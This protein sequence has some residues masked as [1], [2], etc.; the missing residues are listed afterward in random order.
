MTKKELIAIPPI[1]SVTIE[2]SMDIMIARD[3]ARRAASL[4]GFSPA[5]RAQLAGAAAALAELVLKTGSAHELNYN[6]VRNGGA[7]TGVQIS[8]TAPWLGSVAA[9]NVVIA[10][11][12]KMGD[13]VDD[14]EVKEGDAPTIVMT[15]WLSDPRKMQMPSD[16][17]GVEV[18]ASAIEDDDEDED[19]DT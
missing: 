3:T 4:L 13:L 14:I 2:D 1:L 17:N 6:G 7:R 19:G 12:A 15:M 18:D 10:L 9:S 11:R 16:T 5:F 8:C